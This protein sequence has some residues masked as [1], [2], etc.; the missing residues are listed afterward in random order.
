MSLDK[1]Q[2]KVHELAKEKGWWDKP[3]SPLEVHMLIVS[4]I[5]EATEEARIGKNYWYEGPEKKPCGEQMEL[6]DAVIRI[7][8]YFESN[9][10]SLEMAIKEKHWYNRGRSYRHGNKAF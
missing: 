8:D 10:W 3:R 1:W 7:M 5:A 9:G 6:A 2:K 4:E